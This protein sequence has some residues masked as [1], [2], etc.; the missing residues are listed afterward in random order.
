MI[1]LGWFLEIISVDGI[2]I[3]FVFFFFTLKRY[4]ILLL[5]N[6]AKNSM[7]LLISIKVAII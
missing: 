6:L 1:Y 7:E 2:I 4:L 3:M 5:V